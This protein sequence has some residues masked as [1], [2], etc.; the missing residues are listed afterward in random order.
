MGDAAQVVE[1]ATALCNGSHAHT[2][3]AGPS[4]LSGAGLGVFVKGFA[5]KGTVLTGYH[6]TV[7]DPGELTALCM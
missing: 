1:G 4:S 7:F 3:E 5:A 6:G 2:L